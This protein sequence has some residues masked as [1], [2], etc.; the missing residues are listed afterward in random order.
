MFV[1]IHP[2]SKPTLIFMITKTNKKKQSKSHDGKLI[3][4]NLQKDFHD[5]KDQQK[6]NSNST[7]E[8]FRMFNL[9]KDFHDYKPTTKTKIT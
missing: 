6:N 4:F 3:M 5:Y 7:M 9:Q 2:N 1:L 8:D